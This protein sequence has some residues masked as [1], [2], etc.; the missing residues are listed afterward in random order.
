M[1]IKNSSTIHPNI[2]EPVSAAI[3]IAGNIGENF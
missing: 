3:L 2:G 1:S